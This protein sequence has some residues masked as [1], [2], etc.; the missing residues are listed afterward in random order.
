VVLRVHDASG[1]GGEL[2]VP[3]R[4]GASVDLRGHELGTFEG[5]TTLRP[6]QILTLRLD[7]HGA[8]DTG[9]AGSGRLT[10]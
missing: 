4:R 8:D 3:G 9:P 7:P 10:T 5:R 2:E 1:R 6:H